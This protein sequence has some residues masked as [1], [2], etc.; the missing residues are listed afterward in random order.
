[1]FA[2]YDRYLI[3]VSRDLLLYLPV[4]AMVIFP[5]V[6]RASAT[7][8]TSAASNRP[9]FSLRPGPTHMARQCHLPPRSVKTKVSQTVY[10]NGYS[11]FEV[12]SS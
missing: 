7:R 5:P 6:T 9:R 4:P 11:W 10:Q 1:M 3:T 12:A 2:H 8:I